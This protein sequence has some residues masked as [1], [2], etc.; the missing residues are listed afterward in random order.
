MRI[1]IAHNHYQQSGGED[2]V[3]RAECALLREFKQDVRLYERSNAELNGYSSFQK[4]NHLF[5]LDWS[6]QSFLE[7]KKIIREFRPDVVHF[8]NIFFMITPA[9]Y[10]ACRQEGVPVIQSQHNFRLLCSNALF[11]RGHQVCEECTKK[12]LW[13]G[14]FYGCYRNS[15]ITTAFVVRMLNKHWRKKTWSQLVDRYITATEFTRQK[16]IAGGIPQERIVVKPHFVYPDLAERGHDG[17]YVL[18]AGRLSA[19]KG[20]DVLLKAWQAHGDVALKIL[21]EGPAA[22]GLKRFVQASNVANVDFL[23]YVP[24]RQYETTMSQAKFLV[25]PSICYD[26]FPRVIAE[27]YACGIPVLASRIGSMEEYVSDR[28]TGILFKPGDSDDLALKIRWMLQH[29]DELR[30]MGRWARQVYEKKY[31]AR[32]NYEHLM[33]IYRNVV[34]EY[35]P[36]RDAVSLKASAS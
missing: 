8:H 19:E 5:R 17:G 14:V 20:V 7:M 9:A 25:V 31:R 2:E 21:G 35:V 24:R 36:K 12:T 30:G 11:L 15:R 33:N 23:G 10:F 34:A 27:A 29:P 13:R 28:K 6:R 18:Y 22:D 4:L 3:V 32:E 26:N 16:F 1:L